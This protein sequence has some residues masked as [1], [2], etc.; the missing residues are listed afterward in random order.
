VRS[1]WIELLLARQSSAVERPKKTLLLDPL[2][3]EDLTSAVKDS[4]ADL[5]KREDSPAHLE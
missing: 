2:E 3:K 5:L 1:N 4:P